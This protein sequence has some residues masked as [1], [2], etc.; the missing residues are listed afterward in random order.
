MAM[1]GKEDRNALTLEYEPKNS[2]YEVEMQ[3][4]YEVAGCVETDGEL[5]TTD[6]CA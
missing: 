3:D 6:S 4:S 5:V 2:Q 1:L